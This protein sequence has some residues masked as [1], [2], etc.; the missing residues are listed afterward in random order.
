MRKLNINRKKP[1]FILM[2]LCVFFTACGSS[3]QDIL[4]ENKGEIEKTLKGQVNLK[5]RYGS[6]SS[7]DK[8]IK[9][10]DIISVQNRRNNYNPLKYGES[11]SE[12]FET[13]LAVK[14]KSGKNFIIKCTLTYKPSSRNRDTLKFTLHSCQGTDQTNYVGAFVGSFLADVYKF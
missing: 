14:E 5:I 13:N 8:I 1:I 9:K 7:L 12:Y 3:S 6:H 2:L 4:K 11:D 10:V